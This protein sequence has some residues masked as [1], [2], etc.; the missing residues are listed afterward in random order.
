[1]NS[2]NQNDIMIVLLNIFY[3][4]LELSY[5]V[6]LSMRK[7]VAK[8]ILLSPLSNDLLVL[9]VYACYITIYCVDD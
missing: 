6:E 3:T 1:M 9:N 7:Q 2:I 8:H 4:Y 5:Y